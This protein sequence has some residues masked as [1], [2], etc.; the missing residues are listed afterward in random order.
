MNY[1][2][3]QW[4]LLIT[5]PARGD[6]NMALDEAIMESVE[7]LSAMPTLRLY[8]WE[9]AC[10]SLGYAQP[11]SDIDHT[12]LQQFGWDWVRRSTGGRAILHTD[13][14][15]YSVIAPISDSRVLGGVLDSYQRLSIALLASLH[16]LK[17]PAISRADHSLQ[18]GQKKGAVCFEVPSDYE[19]VVQGKKLVGSAQLRRRN[20]LL[21][22]GTLPLWGDITRITQVLSF[23]DEQR[24][25]DAASRLL[26][27]ATTVE[28]VLGRRANWHEVVQAFIKGFESELNLEFIASPILDSENHRANCLVEEKYAKPAW[29]E[30]I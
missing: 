17:I 9:P 8:S 12:R 19:I 4:R 10:L 1:P 11:S 18:P 16:L 29:L 28:M 13:E 3:Q 24:R 14:L 25:M 27:H 5:P 23:P 6:W 2:F 15:T 20:V 7:Q 26:V 30:R 22:H 21:Q